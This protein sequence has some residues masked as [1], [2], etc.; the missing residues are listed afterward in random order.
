M[1]YRLSNYR[2]APERGL[3]VY[4]LSPAL[5]LAPPGD[6]VKHSKGLKQWQKPST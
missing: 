2:H 6:G 3:N 5:Q 4:S 1:R